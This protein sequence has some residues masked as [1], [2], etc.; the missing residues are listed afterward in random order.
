MTAKEALAILCNRYNEKFAAVSCRDYGN[1]YAFFVAPEGTNLRDRIFVG[2]EM[3]CVNK[4][5]GQVTIEEIYNLFGKNYMF[6]EDV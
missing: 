5:T 4:L 3:M 6:V 1:F 2:C